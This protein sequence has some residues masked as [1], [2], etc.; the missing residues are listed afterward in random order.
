MR[1]TVI[2]P[3]SSEAKYFDRKDVEIAYCGV[4]LTASAY[5][6]LKAI[7]DTKPDIIIMG[8][9]AGAYYDRGI[10]I[11]ETFLVKSETEADLGF[12]HEDGFKHLADMDLDM[13]FEVKR[14]LHCPYIKEDMPLKSA[15]SISMNAAMSPYG[16][17]TL[18][19]LEN[20]EG[21][22]FFY[23]AL[24]EGVRF[25][26]VRSVSNM[27]DLCRDDWDYEGSIT[28]LAEGLNS[29]IDYLRDETKA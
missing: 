27:V 3:T 9:I 12:F 16:D 6:T 2:F 17:I 5:G 23:V 11:G 29:I 15:T 21:S 22:A 4:G 18:G 13:E 10:N 20:M 7:Y 14:T 26:H 8:G 19:D 25:L 24:K 1:I 28:R